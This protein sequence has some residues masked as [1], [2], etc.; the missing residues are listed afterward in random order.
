MSSAGPRRLVAVAGVALTILALIATLGALGQESDAA[1]AGDLMLVASDVAWEPTE[2][3]TTAGTISILV[4]NRDVIAHDLAID[5]H[6]HLRVPGR[7]AKRATVRLATGNYP[8][9][10]TLHP[11]MDGLLR[12]TN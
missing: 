11:G 7:S 2:I 10:C 9:H 3:E 8:F 4:D 12:I 5:G 6:V 1:R